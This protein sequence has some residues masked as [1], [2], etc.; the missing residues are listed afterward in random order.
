MRRYFILILFITVSL[1]NLSIAKE[2]KKPVELSGGESIT[3]RGKAEN[4]SLIPLYSIGGHKKQIVNIILSKCEIVR[5]E[6]K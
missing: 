3:V 2:D 6:R 4:M 1:P 5:I